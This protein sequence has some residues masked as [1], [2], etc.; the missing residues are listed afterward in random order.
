MNTV[1]KVSGG[2]FA[3]NA[4]MFAFPSAFA[5]RH[6]FGVRSWRPVCMGLPIFSLP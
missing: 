5:L 4:E 6:C 2:L 3:A 1:D